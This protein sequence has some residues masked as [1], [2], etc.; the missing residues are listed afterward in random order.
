[1]PN[2]DL[3]FFEPDHLQAVAR[4]NFCVWHHAPHALEEVAQIT[5]RLE[6]EQIELEQRAQEPLLLW[7][8]CKNVVRRKRDM[9]EKRQRSMHVAF[10]QRLRDVHQVII[11][12]PDKIIRLRAPGD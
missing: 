3:A 6:A 5:A 12:H 10:T 9:Q 1:M 4:K 11:V 2:S 8:L 7:K